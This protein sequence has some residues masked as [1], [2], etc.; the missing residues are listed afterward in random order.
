MITGRALAILFGTAAPLLWAGAVSAGSPACA[1]RV[2]NTHAK[3]LECVTQE[4][5]REHQEAFQAIADAHNGIR[6]SGTPGYDASAD[7]VRKKLEAAGY[8]VT[9]QEFPFQTFITLTLPVLE[10]VSPAPAGPIANIILSY[11]GSGDVTAAVTALSAPPADATP[12]C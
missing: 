3:L 11:S 8:A 4:G 2:N 12:G 5:A 1:N 9:V 10:R 7:Y 6:T